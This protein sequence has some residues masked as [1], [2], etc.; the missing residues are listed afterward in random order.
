MEITPLI[1][2]L[3]MGFGYQ[4][5]CF[6]SPVRTFNPPTQSLLSL[7]EFILSQ[8]KEAGVT[9]LLALRSG[10]ERLTPNINPHGLISFRQGVQWDIITREGNKPLAGQSPTDGYSLDITFNRAGE[11]QFKDAHIPNQQPVS[12]QL[13]ASLPEGKRVIA[14]SPFKSWISWLIAASDTP[15][16]AII[17]PSKAFNYILK[18]LSVYC[19]ILRKC[20]FKFN[21]LV[22]L[23]KLGYKTAVGFIGCDTLLKSCVV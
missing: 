11:F 7:S 6:I 12:F 5:S 1:P 9:N 16:K 15:E 13:P 4:Y 3:F 20:L 21:K 2:N 17:S 22:H 19:G 18:N 23:V 8:F 10:Q 14:I